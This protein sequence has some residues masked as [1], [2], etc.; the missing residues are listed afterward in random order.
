VPLLLVRHARAG[1]RELWEADDRLRPLDR[2]GRRQAVALVAALGP[3]RVARI[4]SSPYLRCLQTVTPLAEAR[5]L[6][7]EAAEELGE[8]LQETGGA[9]LVRSLAREDAVICGHGGLEQALGIEE[10][11]R[12]GATFVLDASLQVAD[13]LRV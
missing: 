4:V 3:L 9:D 13:E 2:R 12:K 5:G 11:W 10:R 7:V 1:K 6:R 8:E